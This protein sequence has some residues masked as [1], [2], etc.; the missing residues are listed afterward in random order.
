MSIELSCNIIWIT[1]VN[2]ITQCCIHYKIC[3]QMIKM[4]QLFLYYCKLQSC[5]LPEAFPASYSSYFEFYFF[6]AFTYQAGFWPTLLCCFLIKFLLTGIQLL[7]YY[8]CYFIPWSNFFY[9]FVLWRF[10]LL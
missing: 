4:Q 9:F 7:A 6:V 5:C 10:I 8:F 3:V 2:N 1:H